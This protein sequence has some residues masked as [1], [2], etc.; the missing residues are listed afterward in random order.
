MANFIKI[1]FAR[2]AVLCIVLFL[3]LSFAIEDI[4]DMVP[5]IEPVNLLL[6]GSGLIGLSRFG[7][8][9]FLEK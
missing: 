2:G 7:R 1:I 6:L 5:I 8:K 3:S 4:K 9:K